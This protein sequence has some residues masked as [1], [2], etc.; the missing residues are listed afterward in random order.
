MC[1]F[2]YEK[3]WLQAV[4]Q[5]RISAHEWQMQAQLQNSR[6]IQVLQVYNES[7]FFRGIVDQNRPV[8]L[9]PTIASCLQTT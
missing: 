3:K 2:V 6:G 8:L 4:G 9:R 5:T 1:A 7:A